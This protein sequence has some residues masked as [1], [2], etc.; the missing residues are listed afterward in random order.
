MKDELVRLRSV[1]T[2]KNNSALY[3]ADIDILKGEA[4]GII[5]DFHSGKSLVMGAIEGSLVPEKGYRFYK[6]RPVPWKDEK[7]PLRTRHLKNNYGLIDNMTIWEN[8]TV[9]RKPGEGILLSTNVKNKVQE[10]I[11]GY[12]IRLDADTAVE[13]LK[14]VEKFVVAVIKEI[15]RGT[16]LIM[17]EDTQLEYDS[18]AFTLMET[19]L[20]KCRE[21]GVSVLISGIDQGWYSSLLDRIN[22]IENGRCIWVD[23]RSSKGT[24]DTNIYGGSPLDIGLDKTGTVTG[25]LHEALRISFPDFSIGARKGEFIMIIDPE[26]TLNRPFKNVA[27]YQVLGPGALSR[28]EVRTRQIDFTEFGALIRWMTPAD[29][30]VFGLDDRISDHGLLKAHLKSYFLKEFTEWSGN[31]KYMDM[32]D[33]Q[34]L[35]IK[36]RIEMAVFKLRIEKPDVLIFRHFQILDQNCRKMVRDALSELTAQGSIVVGIT[37]LERFSDLADGYYLISGGSCSDRMDHHQIST[38]LIFSR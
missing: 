27:A 30:L 38:A 14:P 3:G 13:R 31:K 7:W 33:C 10:L 26:R 37:T 35:T 22:Y 32:T 34:G 18:S 5:G 19:L 29:N 23:D 8:M 28:R 2:K 21:M 36:D 20:K 12:G 25:N 4:V 1:Y 16:E 6:G 9:F 11:Y 24:F 15:L 17:A